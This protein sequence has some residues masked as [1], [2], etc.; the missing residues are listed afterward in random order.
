MNAPEPYEQIELPEGVKKLSLSRDARIPN[1][2]N[3]VVQRE[4]H[5]VGNLV[6][7]QLLNNP[8]VTF[9]GYQAPHPLE[10]HITLKVQAR[11]ADPCEA[12]T[13]ALSDLTQEV[14]L[15]EERFQ[16]EVAARTADGAMQDHGQWD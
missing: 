2:V 16:R 7:M 1:C 14:S 13:V 6:R 12:L 11:G 3:A 15:L 5:T 8:T 10:H 4:D 9:A